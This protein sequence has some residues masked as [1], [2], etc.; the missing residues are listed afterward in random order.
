MLI[1][2]C[3]RITW[4]PGASIGGIRGL[5]DHKIC[6]GDSKLAGMASVLLSPV[7]PLFFREGRG[8]SF[9]VLVVIVVV[10]GCVA[11]RGALLL[12]RFGFF[13][14]FGSVAQEFFCRRLQLFID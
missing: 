5:V 9:F 7:Q 1:N 6:L 12:R 2:W 10:D 11:W 8:G 13:D 4:G 3:K 14:L